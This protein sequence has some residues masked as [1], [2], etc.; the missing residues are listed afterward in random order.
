MRIVNLIFLIFFAG[1][2]VKYP[3]QTNTDQVKI[4]ELNHAIL[5]MSPSINKQEAK[6]VAKIS[7]LYPLQLANQYNLTSPPLF[8]NTLINMNIK[9]RGFCY[10]FAQ[11]LIKKLKQTHAKTIQFAWVSHKKGNYWEHNAV[12]L[13]A[14]NVPF[15]KSIVLDAWRNSGQLYF[16]TIKNDTSYNWILDIPKSKYYGTYKG[17]L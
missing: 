5:N 1:C 9:K 13:S 6:E 7:V 15:S 14:K 2:S 16:S 10:H 17:D 11:D 12:L 8:H 4:M 3:T